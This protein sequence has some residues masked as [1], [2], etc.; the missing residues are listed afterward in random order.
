[1]K[2]QDVMND[3][4]RLLYKLCDEVERANSLNFYDINISSE[5]LFLELNGVISIY[6]IGSSFE[7]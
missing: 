3:C 7:K 2:E 6:F 4:S 1:M 5:Y